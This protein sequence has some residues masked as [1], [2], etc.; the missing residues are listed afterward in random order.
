[1]S[2]KIS[3]SLTS[4]GWVFFSFPFKKGY[5]PLSPTVNAAMIQRIKKNLR[6]LRES[7]GE[8]CKF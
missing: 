3:F 2:V 4:N 6:K 1:M 8:G 7:E 5:F